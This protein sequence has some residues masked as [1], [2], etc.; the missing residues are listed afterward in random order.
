MAKRC[1]QWTKV[2][3]NEGWDVYYV[4]VPEFLF[5]YDTYEEIK[6]D[7]DEQFTE[8]DYYELINLF[9]GITDGSAEDEI[10]KVLKMPIDFSN[11]C[12]CSD[13]GTASVSSMYIF[14][15]I[16]HIFDLHHIEMPNISSISNMTIDNKNGWGDFVDSEYL[17]IILNYK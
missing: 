9:K 1:W 10:N 2:Y 5:E 4:V 6:K 12:E 11:A 3:W 13:F 14:I 17:S 15:D 7:L 8:K 16:K